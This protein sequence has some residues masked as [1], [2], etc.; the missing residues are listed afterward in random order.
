MECFPQLKKTW[1]HLK[2]TGMND[3]KNYKQFNDIQL[4]IIKTPI[5]IHHKVQKNAEAS[6]RPWAQMRP[7][8]RT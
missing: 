5:N 2:E 4:R 1:W 3:R 8:V 6:E 7:E